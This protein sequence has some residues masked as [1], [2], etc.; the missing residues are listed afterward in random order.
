MMATLAEKKERLARYY[1]AE[2]KILASQSWA[3]KD[4][5]VVHTQ[6]LSVQ[7]QI[8]ELEREIGLEEGTTS[9]SPVVK[10]ILVRDD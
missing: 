4:K 9:G 1:A 2:V 6:L 5:S 3:D 8:K 7:K 10:R